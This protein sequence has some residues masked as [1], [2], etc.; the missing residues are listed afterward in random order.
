MYHLLRHILVVLPSDQNKDFLIL[1]TFVCVH[2]KNVGQIC[3][4]YISPAVMI[5]DGT[6]FVK[7]MY[8]FGPVI[9]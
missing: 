4:E 8:Y 6:D 5:L 7:P 3:T 2:I 1:T 9:K